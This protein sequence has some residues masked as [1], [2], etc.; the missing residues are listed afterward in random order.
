MKK[1]FATRSDC[2]GEHH[3]SPSAYSNPTFL[4]LQTNKANLDMRAS[5]SC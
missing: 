1:V 5:S 3:K 4:S 2:T